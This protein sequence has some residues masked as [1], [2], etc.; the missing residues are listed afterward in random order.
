[1][2][3]SGEIRLTGVNSDVLTP[4]SIDARPSSHVGWSGV[5]PIVNNGFL[6]WV[7]DRN[8]H[9]YE[10]QPQQALVISPTDVSI[11]ASH[12]VDDYTLV[13]SAQQSEPLEIE[14]FVRDDGALLGLT[15]IPEQNIRAWH[16]HIP[17][18]TDAKVK[19]ACV[20]AES[21][22]DHLYAIIEQTINSAT[23][24]NVVRMARIESPVDIAAPTDM[25]NCK[26]L[27]LCKTYS[28]VST[29]TITG[30]GHLEG[31]TVYAV[32]DGR[33]EGPFIVVN[34]TVTLSRAASVVHVGLLYRPE[35]LT[36]PATM[37]VD[38]FGKGQEL[39][40]GQV[41]VRV[42]ESCSFQ[43]S[44]FSDDDAEFGYVPP[45]ATAPGFDNLR[46]RSK[47]VPVPVEGGWNRSSQVYITQDVPL[48][49][50]IVSLTLDV[51]SGGP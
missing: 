4:T 6:L 8:G 31:E 34:A 40:I 5:R 44:S 22:G 23:V 29:A 47:D 48:P 25:T 30:L 24:Y 32:A 46:I 33:V 45:A 50:T 35:I 42:D 19:S 3:S 17:A 20:I 10:V 28:G 41:S 1:M 49:L 43:V 37:L 11:R 15:H 2:T 39:N 9:V 27:D 7:S 16:V 36:L 21:D 18:G 38:G 51:S 12:L 14:W 13:Q 26:N